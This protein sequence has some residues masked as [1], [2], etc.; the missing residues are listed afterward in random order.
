MSRRALAA[1]V[2]TCLL[3]GV[4]LMIGFEIP[5]TRALGVACLSAFVAGG[6]FLIVD[7]VL[8]SDEADPDVDRF[9]HGPTPTGARHGQEG[10]GCRRS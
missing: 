5:L 6:L 4:V 10:P 2:P 9:A 3:A 7:P 8:L 1:L